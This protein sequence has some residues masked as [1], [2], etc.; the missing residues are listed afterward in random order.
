[1]PRLPESVVAADPW[2]PLTA[3]RPLPDDTQS[4][5]PPRAATWA[6]K[7]VGTEPLNV[8]MWRLFV[9]APRATAANWGARAA[10]A[11]P[12]GCDGM[13]ASYT[14]AAA[15]T[16]PA[17][18]HRDTDL[19]NDTGRL[20]AKGTENMAPIRRVSKQAPTSRPAIVRTVSRPG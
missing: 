8:T 16:S 1:M 5:L 11:A 17:V 18:A 13:R 6:A 3:A 14:H 9:A 12:V 19:T 4:T 10:V 2:R 15:A 20:R 7:S